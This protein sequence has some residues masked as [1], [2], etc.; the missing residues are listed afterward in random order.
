MG[1]DLFHVLLS[2]P[3]HRDHPDLQRLLSDCSLQIGLSSS[4]GS[5][6][7]GVNTTHSRGVYGAVRSLTDTHLRDVNERYISEK[8]G[9]STTFAILMSV[10]VI[11]N[12]AVTPDFNSDG[13][14]LYQW[15]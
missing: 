8:F 9:K 11:E 2:G 13:V 10:K 1:H 7:A 3:R 4:L 14:V 5:S 15:P 6:V 12:K